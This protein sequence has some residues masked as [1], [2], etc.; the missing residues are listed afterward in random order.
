MKE[1]LFLN[2]WV[3]FGF[4]L[5]VAVADLITLPTK[6]EFGLGF[7]LTGIYFAV[8]AFNYTKNWGKK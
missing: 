8:G 2:F 3:T 6:I 5:L 4:M 7:V 1:K